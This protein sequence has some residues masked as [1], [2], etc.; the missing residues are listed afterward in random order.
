MSYVPNTLTD[1][2]LYTSLCPLLLSF[3]FHIKHLHRVLWLSWTW[4]T[5][6]I[7]NLSKLN[8]DALFLENDSIIFYDGLCCS[9]SLHVWIWC[10][11]VPLSM[12]PV[13][14]DRVRLTW[15]KLSVIALHNSS[16][17][18]R[19]RKKKGR[20]ECYQISKEQ[21]I[22]SPSILNYNTQVEYATE[23]RNFFCI[24]HLH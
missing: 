9:I 24:S 13:G 14:V 1:P 6:D 2:I 10:Y 15:L 18:V 7:N 11:S 4:I 12:Y 3:I 20:D 21:F 16:E 23:G 22:G 17:N 8:T 5:S 19:K